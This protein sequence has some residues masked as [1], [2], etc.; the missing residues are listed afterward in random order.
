MGLMCYVCKP[1][2]GMFSFRL[3]ES[4]RVYRI[5]FGSSYNHIRCE[6]LISGSYINDF[7]TLDVYQFRQQCRGTKKK[8]NNKNKNKFKKTIYLFIFAIRPRNRPEVQYNSPAPVHAP[9]VSPIQ[10][11]IFQ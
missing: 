9:A 3:A 6:D 2:M 4:Q 5:S 7:V 1:S 11:Q 8:F 10:E